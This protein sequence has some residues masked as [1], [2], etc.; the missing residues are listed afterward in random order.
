MIVVTGGL[1]FIGSNLIKKLNSC[2]INNIYIVDKKKKYPWKK[3][4]LNFNKYYY[5]KKFFK[6]LYSNKIKIDNIVHMGANT[7]TQE[8]NTRKILFENYYF[9]KDLLDICLKKKINFFY[10][11]SASI[12]GNSK[13]FEEKNENEFPLNPYAFSKFLFDQYVRKIIKKKIPIKIIGFRYFN[14][15]GPGEEHKGSMASPV[16]KFF[17]QA[18][19][20]FKINIFKSSKKYN[21]R[22]Y[23]RD[24]VSINDV[25]DICLW[26]MKKKKIKNDIYNIGT[27]R[28]TSFYKIALI[29]KKYFKKKNIDIRIDKINFPEKLE[30]SYQYYTKSSNKKLIN[31]G[32]NSKFLCF[33]KACILYLNYL[34][35]SLRSK[36]NE[37]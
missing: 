13:N 10:A 33:D 27:S 2:G 11:S 16:L 35:G 32:Y 18:K 4:K 1:G 15:F 25:V 19:K 28:T 31:A 29:V 8:W 6:I 14:V 30:E 37:K 34:I 17:L 12:Y 22:S 20:N 9:S 7:N 23:K 5:Y 21:F 36:K 3:N 24:F 26:F